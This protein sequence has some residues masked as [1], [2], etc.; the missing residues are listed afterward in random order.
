LSSAEAHTVAFMDIGTNSIRLLVVRIHPDH[1]STVLTQLKQMVRLGDGAFTHQ[2]LQPDA[3]DR[4]VFVARQFAQLAR[5]N[6]AETIITV[7]TAATRE[8][9]N[10]GA[11]VQ[12]LQQEAD[13]DVRVVSGLE[14]ARLIYLGVVSGVH[15]GE[16]QAFLMDIGGGSTE[17]I[18]GTQHHHSYLGSLK[19]G[20]IRLTA[21]C[22]AEQCGPVAPHKYEAMKQYARHHAMRTLRELC[23]YRIDLAIGSSGTIESLA[24]IAARHFLKQ[25]RQRDDVLTYAS[26][27]QVIAMLSALPLESRRKVLGLNPERADIIIAGAAILDVFMQGLALKEIRVSARGVREG[28]LVDYLLKHGASSLL[29]EMSVRA[30]SVWQLAHTCQ[31]D[32]THARTTA[33]LAL[34]LFDSARDAGLHHCGAWERELLEYTALLHHIGAFLTCTDYQAHTYYLIKH[35]NLL[36]F[37]QTEIAI[38]ATTALYHRKALPRKKHPEFAAL[39]QRVQQI[40]RILS[41]LLRLAENLDRGHAGLIRNVRLC[42]VDTQHVALYINAAHACQVEVWGV[43]KQ[44][45]AFEKVFGRQLV[46]KVRQQTSAK[47]AGSVSAPDF[48]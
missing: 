19:L 26:L 38:M 33:R 4:A 13:L 12:Q 8:A 11:L 10:Q 43:Q 25:P 46:I 20:A 18:I 45:A 41:G 29:Q 32:A 7:A 40:V 30:R 24:D 48:I 27:Q 16:K 2:H 47:A 1:S 36:G 14:E 34:A 39:D 28:L 3:I 17:V 37:D 42:A 22:L 21:Q 31:C 35:A 9:T 6:G 15:L 23:T 44:L 5:A